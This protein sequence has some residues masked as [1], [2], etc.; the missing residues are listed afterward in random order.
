MKKFCFVLTFR[1]NL[2]NHL[3]FDMVITSNFRVSF[4][5]QFHFSLTIFHHFLFFNK[6]PFVSENGTDSFHKGKFIFFESSQDRSILLKPN[7]LRSPSPS[8][9]KSLKISKYILFIIL[10]GMYFFKRKVS[11]VIWTWFQR[12]KQGIPHLC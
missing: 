7:W 11:K 5:F 12:S 1:R 8:C 3:Y 9:N 4:Y 10:Y 6:T 2:K